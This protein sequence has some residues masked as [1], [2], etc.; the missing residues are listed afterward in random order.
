M[1]VKWKTTTKMA[2]DSIT[3]LQAKN[4]MAALLMIKS[5]VMDATTSS[6]EQSMK[7]IGAAA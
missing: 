4:M 6:E 3:M 2:G 7:E 5:M 1:K